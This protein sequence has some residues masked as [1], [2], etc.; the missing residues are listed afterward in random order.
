MPMGARNLKSWK[1]NCM[2][3]SVVDIITVA[4]AIEESLKIQNLKR[5]VDDLK[6]MMTMSKIPDKDFADCNKRKTQRK[7]AKV[8]RV[9]CKIIILKMCITH[10]KY[11]LQQLKYILQ[12]F[13]IYLFESITT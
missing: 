6:E 9:F 13:K 12:H 4:T 7:N 8:K 11:I 10:Q 5:K 2:P 1:R 3:D